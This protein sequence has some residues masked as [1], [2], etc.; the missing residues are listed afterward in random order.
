MK[1]SQRN[2]R[3]CRV[4]S[5]YIHVAYLRQC[6]IVLD[7]AVNPYKITDTIPTFWNPLI[8][9]ATVKAISKMGHS[10]A[11]KSKASHKKLN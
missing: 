4:D 9:S 3:T 2:R 5:Q 6:Y 7:G 8:I 1:V 10:L 11:S